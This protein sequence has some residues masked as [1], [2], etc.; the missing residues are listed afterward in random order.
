[1]TDKG[2]PDNQTFTACPSGLG[3]SPAHG[4]DG[5]D[6]RGRG[7]DTRDRAARR[8]S[9]RQRPHGHEPDRFEVRAILYVPLVVVIVL[10]LAYLLTTWLFAVASNQRAAADRQGTQG[11]PRD[12][13]KHE[14]PVE[15]R[16]VRP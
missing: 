4:D 6:D 10:V 2:T 7:V 3:E 12:V 16:A 11:Q 8:Q 9:G 15:R 13:V 1:M 5:V 14:R